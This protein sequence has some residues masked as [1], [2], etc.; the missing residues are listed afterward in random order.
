MAR[1]KHGWF[2]KEAKAERRYIR[3]LISASRTALKDI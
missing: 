2:T 3:E 1:L